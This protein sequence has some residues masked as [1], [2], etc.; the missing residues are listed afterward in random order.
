MKFKTNS[1][2]Y[3]I[4]AL[5]WSTVFW[6]ASALLS[7]GEDPSQSVLFLIGGA[8]PLIAALVLTYTR[9]D[10]RTRG[11]FWVRAYDSRRIR[12]PWSAATLLLHPAIILIAFGLGAAFG[13]PAPTLNPRAGS[14]TSLLTLAFFVFWFG[15]LPEELGWRGFALDRLQVRQTALVASLI[16]GSVWALWHV[17]LFFIPGTFQFELGFG[18]AR[19]WIFLLSNIPLSVLIT[20]VFN[21]TDRSTLSAV[22]IHWTGN[23]TGALLPKSDLVAGLE[24]VLLVVAAAVVVAGWGAQRLMRREAV[25]P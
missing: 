4:F 17:P 16:L 11:D 13:D 19:A 6:T 21:N 25:N 10:R 8:G 5:G 24:L 3:F 12:W 15:P 14:L 1:L 9:E 18:S 2:T 22:L 7:P 23:L 20:W